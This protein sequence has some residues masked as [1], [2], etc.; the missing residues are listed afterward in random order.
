MRFFSVRCCLGLCLVFLAGQTMASG[1]YVVQPGA[2]AGARACAMEVW[3]GEATDTN[4]VNLTCRGDAPFHMTA[5]VGFPESGSEAVVVEGHYQFQGYEQAGYDLGLFGGTSYDT[6]PD[7]ITES[8][9]LVPV[10]FRPVPERLNV[11]LNLGAVH[12]HEPGDTDVFWGAAAELALGGPFTAVAE[13]F[14]RGGNDP[15]VQ[16]GLRATVLDGRLTFDVSYLEETADGGASG[17]AAG[18]AFQ[19]ATF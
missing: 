18:A 9:L 10:T 4:S 17:W 16:G 13:T 3:H 19:V 7:D 1:Q 6:G 8:I 2:V 14:G 11:H 15:T 12:A 5:E